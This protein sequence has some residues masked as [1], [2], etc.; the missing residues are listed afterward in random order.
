MEL[1]TLDEQLRRV[2]VIEGYESL[3]WT[4]R[5]AAWGDFELKIRSSREAR[6]LLPEGTRLAFSRSHRVMTVETI[7]DSVDDEG[8]ETLTISG[9]SLEALLDDRVAFNSLSPLEQQV[10]DPENPGNFKTVVIQWTLEGK[11]ADLVRKLFNDICVTK[12]LS[13]G[14]GFPHHRAG[15][16]F[17]TGS[18]PEPPDTITVTLDP[19]TLYN[20]I[21][22]ICETYNLGF[23][24]VR[25]YETGFLYF[26]VYTGDDRT[27]AQET[28][29]AV[30][31]SPELDNLTNTTT[32]TS[33]AQ[34]KNVAY[35]FGKTG[36]AM[37]YAP[38][39]DPNAAGFERRVLFVKADN[40]DLEPGSGLSSA[41]GQ[42]GL[43]ELAKHRHIFNFDGEIAQTDSYTYGVDYNLGDLVEQRNI[44]GFSN[45]MRVTEQIFVSD[46]EGDRSY[47]TLSVNFVSNPGSWMSWDANQVWS[48]VD[49]DIYWAN[50]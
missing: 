35:V 26:E 14:D 8:A 34:Y 45:Q 27:S 20:S 39:A 19:D 23:R 4:E 12:I 11:P 17:P 44:D 38:G 32:L 10:P 15:T 41:L 50:A 40:I 21:R 31:F 9:R 25:G 18:I 47:P 7:E 13:P 46:S 22:K 6:N 42:R 3:I 37:V 24:V 30:L 2:Q 43:E 33:E 16:I 28:R 1:Y 36:A 29:P 5:Y 49:L 48:Q